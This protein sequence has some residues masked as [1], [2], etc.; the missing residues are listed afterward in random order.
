MA[1]TVQPRN[2]TKAP[3]LLPAPPT[4]TAPDPASNAGDTG[5]DG[6]PMTMSGKIVW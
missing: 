5:P 3:P 6:D 4:G 1:G 2:D